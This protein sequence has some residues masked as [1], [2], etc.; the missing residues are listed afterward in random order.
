MGKTVDRFKQRTG[1]IWCRLQQK[2]Y[3]EKVGLQD[4]SERVVLFHFML[5]VMKLKA[6][7][8]KYICNCLLR[9]ALH[10]K[11]FPKSINK[12]SRWYLE[13]LF[14]AGQFGYKVFIGY[15]INIQ[16]KT[17]TKCNKYWFVMII[18]LYLDI[19]EILL[20]NCQSYE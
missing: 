5:L 10:T 7:Q 17:H 3:S 18:H 6:A 9:I 8:L 12:I 15:T 11:I 20:T 2:N 14:L 13:L 16:I 1:R 19:S 4:H